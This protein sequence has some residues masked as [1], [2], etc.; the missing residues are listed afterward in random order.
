MPYC[1]TCCTTYFSLPTRNPSEQD[2]TGRDTSYVT[3]SN[4]KSL[5]S[6]TLEAVKQRFRFD[7]DVREGDFTAQFTQPK[8][9][10]NKVRFVAHQLSNNVSLLQKA[11][12]SEHVGKPVASPVHVLVC[13][14][15]VF[16]DNEAFVRVLP[17]LVEKT[18]EE[19]DDP[20]SHTS[21]QRISVPP[22][23]PIIQQIRPE[24][25][26]GHPLIKEKRQQPS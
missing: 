20:L 19:C 23:F 26:I 24:K 14:S 17:C 7:V 11:I 16:E 22:K 4:N 21:L 25:G 5:R 10:A 12:R 8:P 1:I 15:L 2:W 9:H 18:V 3:C 13:Q 6:T